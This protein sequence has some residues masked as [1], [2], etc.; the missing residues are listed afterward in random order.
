MDDIRWFAPNDFTRLIVSDLR[1]R[2]LTVVSDGDGPAGLVVAMSGSIA[3]EAWRYAG[4]RRAP[5]VQY[6]WDVKPWW[7]GSGR[8]D[9][10]WSTRGR[11][12]RLPRLGRRY[13]HRRGSLSALRF[14]AKRAVA[15][16]APS[17]FSRSQVEAQLGVTC[18]VVRYCYDSDRFVADGRPLGADAATLLSVSRLVDYKN[19]SAVVLAAATFDPPRPVHLIG[20]GPEREGLEY[21]ARSLDVPLVISADL[22]AD[23]LRQAYRTACVVVC[24][25]RFEGMGLTPI[26]AAACGARVVASD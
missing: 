19:H 2:G 13:R 12:L 22:S 11:L 4:R 26:E 15:V 24:P 17:A 21:L 23:A 14:V 5:L 10:K 9:P 1:G 16:W 18:A 8:W 3:R 7:I 6:V 20:R 25:S